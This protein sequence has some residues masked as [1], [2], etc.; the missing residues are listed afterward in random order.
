MRRYLWP[1]LLARTLTC[2]T[3]LPMIMVGQHSEPL[4]HSVS[5][6]VPR[7]MKEYVIEHYII[8]NTTV[9]GVPGPPVFLNI[10]ST[11]DCESPMDNSVISATWTPPEGMLLFIKLCLSI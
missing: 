4:L 8:A 11:G 5:V 10:S 2:P 9:A 7:T 1:T 6:K 3:P